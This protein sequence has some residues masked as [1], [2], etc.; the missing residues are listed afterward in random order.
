MTLIF[1][2]AYQGKTAYAKEQFGLS[3]TDIFVC[4]G[5]ELSA[6][7]AGFSHLEKFSLA[8][9]KEGKEPIEV[10]KTAVPDRKGKIFIADDISCGVVP[11]DPTLRAWRE[12][13]GR[14]MNAL[15]KEAD[16][17]VRLFCGIGQVI[18]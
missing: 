18:K 12:A 9:V 17:V 16:H 10:L 4:E 2:G 8:C 13:H 11:I 14:M 15:A 3:D 1:G 6:A 5:G 7:A